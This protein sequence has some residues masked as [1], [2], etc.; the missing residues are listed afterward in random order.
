M[1]FDDFLDG[2]IAA[3]EMV[4]AQLPINN[5]L[6]REFIRVHLADAR[7]RRAVDPFSG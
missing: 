1:G 3:L 6:N 4:E 7:A 2:Y 5:D